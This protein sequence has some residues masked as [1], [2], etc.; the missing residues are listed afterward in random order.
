MDKSDGS[1]GGNLR[2]WIDESVG[3]WWVSLYSVG[4]RDK[5]DGLWDG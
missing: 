1:R 3:G 5:R 2:R 4:R